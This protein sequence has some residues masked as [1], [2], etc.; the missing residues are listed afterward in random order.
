MRDDEFD[1]PGKGTQAPIDLIAKSPDRQN[2]LSR[3]F[4]WRNRDA[5]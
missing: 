4:R 2:C 3:I 1:A 5:C